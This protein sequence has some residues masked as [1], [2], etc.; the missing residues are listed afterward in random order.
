MKNFSPFAIGILMV[1]IIGSI[2]LIPVDEILPEEYFSSFQVEYIARSLKMF[3]L[4][5][6]SAWGIKKI[7]LKSLSGL[8]SEYKWTSKWLNLIPIYLFILGFGSFIGNDVSKVAISDVLLL[9]FGCLMVGFAEEF[10][11]RGFLQPLFIQKLIVKRNGL[12][13]GI[14]FPALFFGATHLLNLT[15]NNN[16]PQVLVQCIYATFIGFFFGVLL[17]KTNKL[18][19][20]AITHG[21]IN[22]FFLLGTLPGITVSENIPEDALGTTSLVG[23]IIEYMV[24]MLLVLPLFIIGI[25][26][27]RKVDKDQVLKKLEL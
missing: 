1:L 2:M 7:W 8:S 20:L 5:A 16:V 13:L 22:F 9:L 18:V 27:L 25:V 24:P 26:V 12:F 23:Q 21:L 4:F 19:P 17:L 14:L 6:L 3:V 10:M 11:F 15:V